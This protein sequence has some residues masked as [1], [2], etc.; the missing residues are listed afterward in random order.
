M[1]L[2]HFFPLTVDHMCGDDAV[3]A[4]TSIQRG[5][6]SGVVINCPGGTMNSFMDD[7]VALTNQ[8]FTALG[9]LT[10]SLAVSYF[11]C[12]DTRLALPDSTFS[13]HHPSVGYGDGEYQTLEQLRWQYEISRALIETGRPTKLQWETH[14]HLAWLTRAAAKYEHFGVQ[15][16]AKRTGLEPGIVNQMMCDEV[17]FTAGEALRFGLVHRI[18]EA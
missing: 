4:T 2:L 5:D 9:L 17:S 16:V 3:A 13:L 6:A 12:A 14:Q 10:G 11:L 8:H 18:I 1:N 15:W 7:A